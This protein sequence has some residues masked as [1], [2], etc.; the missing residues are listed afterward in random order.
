MQSVQS[1]THNITKFLFTYILINISKKYKNLYIFQSQTPKI[2]PKPPKPAKV[3][4]NLPKIPKTSQNILKTSQNLKKKYPQS[5]AN[6][7]IFLTSSLLT[8]CKYQ[9]W[10]LP[11]LATSPPHP[12]PNKGSSHAMV[13]QVSTTRVHEA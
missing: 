11:L 5:P 1:P 7:L 8:T 4:Q 13:C 3:F 9:P 10:F 12:S 2:F 6:P